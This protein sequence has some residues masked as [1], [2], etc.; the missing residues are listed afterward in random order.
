[1]SLKSS[2]RRREIALGLLSAALPY[3][4]IFSSGIAFALFQSMGYLLPPPVEPAGLGAYADILGD[5]WFRSSFAYTV[6][7]A[8]SAT[9]IS[10]VLGTLLALL[11][12][13]MSPGMR[14]LATVYKIPLILPH[15]VV[16]FVVLILFDPSGLLSSLAYRLG[17]IGSQTEFPDLIHAPWG[18]GLILAYIIKETPFVTLMVYAMLTR[19]DPRMLT[20]GRMLGC[21]GPELFFALVLPE[22]APV[23]H[24][25]FIILFLYSFGG[26]DIPLVVGGSRPQM[27]SLFIYNLYF[28]ADLEKRPLAMAALTLLLLF[29]LIFIVFYTYLIRRRQVSVRKV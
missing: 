27:I 4:A 12:W 9:G 22:I 14:L 24:T 1:M 6:W 18:G 11:L 8:A 10:L 7:I 25:V 5:P 23:L 19:I 29:S 28:Q 13:R 15:L 17:L 26:V 20:T 21:R 3:L 2:A 16:A